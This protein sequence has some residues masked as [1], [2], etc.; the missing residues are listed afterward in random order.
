[1]TAFN[2]FN[3]STTVQ[4]GSK[5][6]KKGLKGNLPHGGSAESIDDEYTSHPVSHSTPRLDSKKGGRGKVFRC[7]CR[8]LKS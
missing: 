3:G 7:E 2:G 1:M 4:V 8:L 6:N 5:Y